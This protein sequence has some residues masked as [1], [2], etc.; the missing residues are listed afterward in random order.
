MACASGAVV[1]VHGAGGWFGELQA[2]SGRPRGAAGRAASALVDVVEVSG[3]HLAH[4]AEM[5]GEV[6]EV[7]HYQLWTRALGNRYGRWRQAWR[8]HR[9]AVLRLAAQAGPH[10]APWPRPNGRP[11]V[12][13]D[14]APTPEAGEQ[15][16]V[17]EDR[18]APRGGRRGERRGRG[19]KRGG[20]GAGRRSRKSSVAGS[21]AGSEGGDGGSPSR[22][23][24]FE[25]LDEGEES[26][27][28]ADGG[29]PARP[30]AESPSRVRFGDGEGASGGPEVAPQGMGASG[31]PAP[32]GVTSD[33][34]SEPRAV[35]AAEDEAGGV[36]E[37]DDGEEQRADPSVEAGWFDGGH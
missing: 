32:A 19:G 6:C 14:R 7:L 30:G 2:L 10:E 31:S 36:A 13:P 37:W 8:R 35:G 22:S 23:A 28:G 3:A 24:F 17:Q 21:V 25:G 15:P 29:A 26:I 4:L 16:E 34:G 20:G 12:D 5:Y 18:T 33:A 27:A 11:G 1:R 9:A